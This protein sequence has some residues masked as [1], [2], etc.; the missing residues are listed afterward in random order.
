MIV[1][2]LVGV[3]LTITASNA[4]V[5]PAPRGADTATSS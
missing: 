3:A 2:T 5:A 4:L 1:L